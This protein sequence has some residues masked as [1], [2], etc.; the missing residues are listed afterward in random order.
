MKPS[1]SQQR[2][3]REAGHAPAAGSGC[4]I[5]VATPIGNLGDITLRALDVLGRV[6]CVAAEDTRVTAALFARFGF[7]APM[8][9]LHAHNERER[10]EL[11]VE[12]L[13]SGQS[14][15]LVTDAGTPGISDPGAVLIQR[16]RGA[17]FRIEPI[18]GPSALTA[19]LSVS[20]IAAPP[21]TFQ[22]FAPTK[23]RQRRAL[24]ERLARTRQTQVLF[25]A[26]HRIV[27]TL[28]DLA[29]T[30]GGERRVTM[31][32]ELTKRF[33]T[34]EE[35]TLAQAIAKLEADADQRRGEFVLIVAAAEAPDAACVDERSALTEDDARLFAILQRELPAARAAKL[36]AEFTG[37][38]RAAFYALSASRN[39]YGS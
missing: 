5:L 39:D 22:G 17:G 21:V 28:R 30:F 3:K 32:R 14:V 35:S 9:A 4:L 13:S 26:P 23:T 12:R 38:P 6:D 2:S 20:G 34:I 15:A 1:H 36:A 29:A 33:E 27:D 31:A 25:E 37:K 19:A 24:F 11:V 10:A 16:V 7:S 8:L 18:P